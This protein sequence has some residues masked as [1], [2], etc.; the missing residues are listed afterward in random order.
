MKNEP[1]PSEMLEE[2]ADKVIL[3]MDRLA[4]T[5]FQSALA[6]MINFHRFLIEAYETR[7][8]HGQTVSFAQF[9]EW[10]ALHEE[11][12]REYRR[13]FERATTY[14]GRENYFV[15]SLAHVPRRLLPQDGRHSSPDVTTRLLDLI[16]ILGHF[17]EAWLT[18]HR[19]YEPNAKSDE[20]EVPRV[21]GSDKRAYEEVVIRLVGAWE[22]TLQIVDE[23]FRWRIREIEPAEQWRRFAASW[24]F[25]QQ[26]LRNSAYLLAVAVWNEDEIGAE[27]YAEMLLRW[28][29]GL[30]HQLEDDYHLIR[31]LLI[32]DLLDKQWN[33]ALASLETMVCIPSWDQP[34]PSGVFSAIVQNAL[35]D[36]IIITAGVML[37]WFIE[38]RQGTDIG[39]RIVSRLLNDAVSDDDTHRVRRETGFRPF[40]L[41]LVRI[42]TSGERFEQQGY[43]HCLDGLVAKLD[44]MAERR[45]VPGRVYS[46]STRE[47]REDLLMPWL[48]CLIA[49]MPEEGDAEVVRTV[50]QLT[51][52]E[53]AFTHGDRTLRG[54][55]DNLGQFKSAMGPEHH[56]YLRR[57]AT[58]LIPSIRI[59]ERSERL[60]STLD[61]IIETIEVQR[62]ERLQSCPIDAGKL[63]L[64]QEQVEQALT[65]ESGGIR[66]FKDFTITRNVADFPD[67]E[68]AVGQ[69]KKGYLTKPE[70]AQEPSNIW[71]VVTRT[72]QNFA[73]QYV[74]I[75]LSQRPHRTVDVQDEESY[76]AMLTKEAQP[77]LEGGLEPVLLV[78]EW[79]DPPWI[80]E[81]FSWSGE[82][83]E[84]LQVK[85]R[86]ENQANGYIGT[87]NDI[88]VYRGRL[89]ESQSLLF[90]A[91][92]LKTLGYGSNVDG[93][94]CDVEFIPG[95]DDQ[96][97]SLRFR[98]SQHVEWREDE[99]IVLRYRAAEHDETEEESI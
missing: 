45:V 65:S 84:G 28:F 39:P 96:S 62:R 81:W 47:K 35:S 59:D 15:E 74:W 30:Q 87:A 43:A 50:S 44:S 53:D 64:I 8:E 24:P 55:L 79:N 48:A 29:N 90:R 93:R 42:Y 80:R 37:S 95:Q 32:P 16:N 4:V 19:T 61:G 26:H 12:I 1:G 76:L 20:P 52:R 36:T 71:E 9:G 11:W 98:F 54:L 94:I 86:S 7:D 17:L 46:P 78:R 57:G 22:G 6:E 75:G 38:R 92:L 2:L 21:A 66:V 83:P 25:L 31:T 88:D 63:H 40:F 82:K 67:R 58:A 73:T 10:S 41:Q 23:V 69:I 27:Y 99:V 70:M 77:M 85:R 68:C 3:P 14:I 13:L 18:Q 33:D 5:S 56:E 72:V 49:Q 91:D 97:G 60:V 89:G 34:S 51:G